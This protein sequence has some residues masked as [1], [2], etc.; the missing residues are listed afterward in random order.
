MR[1]CATRAALDAALEPRRRAGKR[2]GFVPTMGALHEGHLTL[3]RQ[4]RANCDLVVASIFVNPTQFGPGEDFNRYPREEEADRRLLESAGCDLLFLPSV[5]EIYPSGQQTRVE[6]E[7]LGSE[8]CGAFRPGHFRGVATVVA[9]LL[10]QVA[11]QLLFLGL[12][13]RQQF[14]LLRRMVRDL[15]MP[16]EVRGVATVREADGLAM[17]SR[18]RYLDARAR[19]QATGL[20]RALQSASSSWRAGVRDVAFLEAVGREILHDAGIERIDY[21]AV[22]DVEH[23][24]PLQGSEEDG[25]MLI[26]AHV[27]QA[28]LIDNMRLSGVAE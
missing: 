11:P 10:H 5:E 22:R 19:H 4:A 21:V 13:D 25:L 1:E 27:G 8:L 15:S 23:L 12:K 14:I 28:R 20:Y 24:A 3:V 18:N 7:P 16:V 9:I 26:A 17:S 6:V 2:I